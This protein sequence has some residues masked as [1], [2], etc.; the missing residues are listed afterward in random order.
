MMNKLVF[1]AAGLF[2]V[3]LLFAVEAS[4]S[5]SDD[6]LPVTGPCH[7][8]FPA[9]HGPHPGYRTE[10]WYYTGNL[11][12]Q[13]GRSFG[14][15]LTFFRS[16]I[17]P[18]GAPASWPTVSSAWRTQQLF[19][20]HAALSDLTAQYYYHSEQ[21]ARG[22][23]G[24]AGATQKQGLT[25]VFLNNWS[26]NLGPS[27][28]RLKAVTDDFGVELTLKPLK[29]PVLHGD[30]GYSRKGR[31]PESASC[32]YSFTRLATNGTVTTGAEKIPVQGLSWMDH[33][34]SSAPL[35]ADLTGWDWFSLQ[36]SD[37][38]ELMIYLLRQKDG[39]FS[40]A[41]SGTFINAS[42]EAL[43][44]PSESFRVDVRDTWQSSRS[45]AI[46]PARWQLTIQSLAMDLS[47]MPNL[48]D[49]EMQTPQSTNVTYWEGSVTV[50]GTARGKR[51][52]GAGYIELTGYAKP[53]D[54]P[55]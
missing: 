7:L 20:A 22:A 55:M 29:A 53:F 35:E 46:Y 54:A 47:I 33:E 15:Q 28:H 11:S 44:L 3:V 24:M 52:S 37:Q 42:S 32:Y 1:C 27:G 34:F 45:G 8:Q 14:F 12:S 23:L 18:P 19:L 49:Q 36:L 40:A 4:A 13:S 16:Q 2:G 6:F 51:V 39:G 10:W 17:S 41:S 26:L 31:D 50:K 43:H 38:T 30:K 21:F 48:A 5:D 9:D 25:H